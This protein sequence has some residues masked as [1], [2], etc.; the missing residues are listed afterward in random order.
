[1]RVYQGPLPR[2]TPP[3]SPGVC[4]TRHPSPARSP[5]PRP[6][7]ATQ[8]IERHQFRTHAPTESAS[9]V[10]WDPGIPS[11][12]LSNFPSLPHLSL[13]VSHAGS[14]D[15]APGRTCSVGVAGLAVPYRARKVGPTP[16]ACRNT[17]T[18][19]NAEHL[20]TRTAVSAPGRAA[21]A[22]IAP[23]VW[24]RDSGTGA[25]VT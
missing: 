10:E 8:T 2:P 12:S 25:G 4:L 14:S 24:A 11:P 1:M 17:A 23:V 16:N 9:P 5:L 21:P 15:P 20:R 13:L 22:G 7:S 6:P 18:V 3:P 19:Y